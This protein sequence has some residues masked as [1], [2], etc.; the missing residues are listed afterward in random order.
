MPPVNGGLSPAGVNTYLDVVTFRCDRGYELVGS[1]SATCQMDGTWNASV[2]DCNAVKC[3]SLTPP[4]NGSLSP[5]GANNYLDV[6]TFRCDRGYELDGSTS[7]TCQADRNWS[8][9]VPTCNA[10]MCPSLTAP[11]NGSLIPANSN[12]YLDVVTFRCDRGYELVGS[13]SA[14]CQAGGSWS[15]SVPTCNAAMCPSLRPPVNGSI[16]NSGAN[17]YMDVV[18]FI[19]DRGYELVGSTR[20]TCQANANW[21]ANV[22][23]C[24]AVKCFNLTAPT[25]GELSPVDA[26]NYQ[27]VVSFRCGR[28]YELV[29]NTSANCQAD[30]NWSANVPIC[31]PVKC[32]SLTAPVNGRLTPTGNTGNTY[33]NVVVFRCNRG[34][35]VVGSTSA[36]CQADRTWSASVPDCDDMD[37]CLFDPCV[38]EATCTDNPPPALDATCICNP[39]YTGDGHFVGTG[40]SATTT[41]PAVQ[42]SASVHPP[43]TCPPCH[44]QASCD[45]V[46][47]NPTCRCN[48]GWFGNGFSCDDLDECSL[49]ESRR[50][51]KGRRE[52][53]FNTIGSFRCDC[54][55]WLIRYQDSCTALNRFYV[56]LLYNASF[57]FEPDKHAPSGAEYEQ[58]R[59]YHLNHVRLVFI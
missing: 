44:A 49:P 58:S 23:T 12:T 7:A 46:R 21:S 1:T 4:V 24:N 20:A 13:T 18:S 41:P 25:N 5:T 15:S 48:T 59:R 22:P 19:C 55:P 3:T 45:D 31:N 2:P 40:C 51:C 37:A 38:P 42:T 57:D 35:E 32:P 39:G 34:Y 36:I 28:G 52:R 27:D 43:V 10:V 54:F 9:N 33:L 53:C 17:T 6:V 29:G 11:V 16:S 56:R 50:P 8:T 30:G 47:P 14:T 26:N